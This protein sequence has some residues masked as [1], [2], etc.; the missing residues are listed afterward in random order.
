MARVGDTC[1]SIGNADWFRGDSES[2]DPVSVL[3]NELLRGTVGNS[4]IVSG[5]SSYTEDPLDVLYYDWSIAGPAEYS[6]VVYTDRQ[7]SIRLD[8]NVVGEYIVWVIKNI[9]F[10]NL[11]HVFIRPKLIFIYNL[12][13]FFLN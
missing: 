1:V 4:I 8:P 2:V 7:E 6:T 10:L 12:F 5:D 11:V 9:C 3:P 13:R